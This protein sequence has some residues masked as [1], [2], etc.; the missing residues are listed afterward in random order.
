MFWPEQSY[1][2]SPKLER[3]LRPTKSRIQYDVVTDEGQ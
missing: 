3:I 2:V 1:V